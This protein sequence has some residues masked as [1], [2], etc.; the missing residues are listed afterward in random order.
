MIVGL[1]NPGREYAGTRHNVGFR[2][3]ECLADR[4][5]TA[6]SREKHHGLVAEVFHGGEK[7]AIIKPLTYMNRSG[8]C[9]AAALR[10]SA[11]EL[12]D[13]L[14]VADDVNLPL[15]KLR[16]RPGGSAGGH[17]GL[18]SIMDHLGVE[19]FARLRIGVGENTSSDNLVNHVLG[20]FSSVEKPVVEEMIP[21]AAEA[22]LR[23]LSAGLDQ[24]MNEF[25][26]GSP[27]DGTP[28]G[29]HDPEVS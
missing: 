22:V 18:Q 2:V 3:V 13:L 17:N 21:R 11:A 5:G 29:R 20:K 1:G 7:V 25:N 26:Q 10:N 12:R 6:F 27:G 4:L 23:F 16:L 9:V 19:D 8:E 14:V 28:A 15:G 24:A